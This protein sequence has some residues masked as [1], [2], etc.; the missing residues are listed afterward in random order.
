MGGLKKRGYAL[1]FILFLVGIILI[2]IGIKNQKK[3]LFEDDANAQ[4]LII[5]GSFMI[6]FSILALMIFNLKK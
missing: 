2:S 1:L 5:V 4:S 6:V 3:D